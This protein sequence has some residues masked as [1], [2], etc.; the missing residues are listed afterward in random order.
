MAAAPLLVCCGGGNE[1]SKS[2]SSHPGGGNFVHIN[3]S[4]HKEMNYEFKWNFGV[5]NGET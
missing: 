5:K 2:K 3:F 1:R 4:L